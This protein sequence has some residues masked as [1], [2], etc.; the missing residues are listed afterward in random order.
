MLEQ[1][2]YVSSVLAVM[3]AAGGV[4]GY[5]QRTTEQ[6]SEAARER[7][8]VAAY[9]GVLPGAAAFRK[10]TA[11]GR[12]VFEGLDANGQVLGLVFTAEGEGFGGP[13][14]LLAAL[15]PRSGRLLAVQVVSHAET[16]GI[17][18]QVTEAGFLKQFHQKPVH[19]AFE[20]GADVQGVSGA[21]ISSRAVAAAVKEA[22]Q[23][24]L[25]GYRPGEAG[26]R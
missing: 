4:L 10:T 7:E 19:E 25:D 24:V 16:P 13:L 18:E 26:R 1:A 15:D 17:G 22:A 12:E 21:T 8:R 5:A 20:V 11:G 9:A 2:R 23:A 6:A 3:L 14:R